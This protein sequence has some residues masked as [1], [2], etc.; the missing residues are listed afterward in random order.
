MWSIQ[1]NMLQNGART[2]GLPEHINQRT[3]NS[4]QQGCIESRHDGHKLT[5]RQQVA[6]FTNKDPLNSLRPRQNGRHF[7]DDI[8]KRI[9]LKE[10]AWIPIKI[11]LKF[12]SKGPIIDIPSLVQTMAWR[13]PGNKPLSESMMV[14]LLTHIC[15][16]RPQRV[17]S[18]PPSAAYTPQ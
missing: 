15:V 2:A 1:I 10:I 16:T 12:V 17:N 6:S 4:N 5:Q 3:I 11:S 18:S 8:F 9:F 14:N 7:A 13:R